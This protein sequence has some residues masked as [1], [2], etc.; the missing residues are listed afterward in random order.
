D[1]FLTLG[2]PR[3]NESVHAVTT[4]RDDDPRREAVQPNVT[5]SYVNT[6]VSHLVRVIGILSGLA[7]LSAC[8]EP[9]YEHAGSPH[10]LLEDREACAREM[11]QSPD[12]LAY[13]RNPAVHPDY[14]SRVF[15]DMNRCIERKGWKLLS[16]QPQQVREPAM[17]ELAQAGRPAPRS[18]EHHRN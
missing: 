11:D 3:I 1:V 12:A 14:L 13:R 7:V 8:G 2:M 10:S 15:T 4:S 16:A 9:V 18:D 17:S 6:T 5:E